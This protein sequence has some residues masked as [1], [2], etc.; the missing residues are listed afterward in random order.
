MIVFSELGG[1]KDEV[2]V[3]AVKV[4][5]QH[6]RTEKATKVFAAGVNQNCA[7]PEYN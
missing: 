5:P 6:L 1:I 3:I 2:V 7:A 4:L